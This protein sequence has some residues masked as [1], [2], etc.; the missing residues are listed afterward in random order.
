[1]IVYWMMYAV[2]AWLAFYSVISRHYR[3][4]EMT[5]AVIVVLFFLVG[6]RQTGGDFPRYELLFNLISERGLTYATT[7]TEPLYGLLNWVIQDLGLSFLSVTIASGLIY[8]FCLWRFVRAEPIPLLALAIATAYLTIVVAMGYTRQGVAIALVM[9]ATLH[10]RRRRPVR[11]ALILAVATGF[12]SSAAIAFGLIYHSVRLKSKLQ[13]RMT[14]V[15]MV[16]IA[17]YGAYSMLQ[18]KADD[19]INLYVNSTRYASGGA[20][21][22]LLLCWVAAGIVLNYRRRFAE[23]ERTLWVTVSFVSLATV[24][25]L[26]VSS[27][28][29]DRLGLYLLPLQIVAFGRLPLFQRGHAQQTATTT[30]VLIAYLMVLGTWLMLGNF[31][32]A[33]WLPYRSAILGV[34]P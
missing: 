30:L 28:V 6:F 26:F 13:T 10:I 27:T 24:I 12:H 11:S 29:A 4:R 2:P 33:L 22:R 34:I 21:Q 8:S 14:G 20:V 1:M 23:S 16:A 3:S 7:Q 19:Y 15:L 31:A 5:G 32:S 18:Q 17:A 9:W 25:L